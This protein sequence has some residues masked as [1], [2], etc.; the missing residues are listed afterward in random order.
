MVRCPYCNAELEQPIIRGILVDEWIIRSKDNYT[1]QSV[2]IVQRLECPCCR[3]ELCVDDFGC[4]ELV[5]H[6]TEDV[7]GSVVG[8]LDIRYDIPEKRKTGMWRMQHESD[9]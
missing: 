1:D 7:I 5:K 8:P 2:F 6:L 3:R 9:L 4:M